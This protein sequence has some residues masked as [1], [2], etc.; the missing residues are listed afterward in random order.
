MAFF[1]GWFRGNI[2]SRMSHREMQRP[3]ESHPTTPVTCLTS[4]EMHM[5][6]SSTLLVFLGG[7]SINVGTSWVVSSAGWSYLRFTE[8]KF[9]PHI[10]IKLFWSLQDKMLESTSSGRWMR[11]WVKLLLRVW[12]EWSV[13][14]LKGLKQRFLFLNNLFSVILSFSVPLA[15]LGCWNPCPVWG[16]RC[17][18]CTS[19]P[20]WQ[21][22]GLQDTEAVSVFREQHK[23][24]LK[25]FQCLFNYVPV[26]QLERDILGISEGKQEPGIHSLLP[27]LWCEVLSE[28]WEADLP[29][30]GQAA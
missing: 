26:S 9:G 17:W 16:M 19:H 28:M 29:C 5:K 21:H 18:A 3:R 14:E 8:G 20:C 7:S 27:G 12:R 23:Y 2:Y 13:L 4:D 11:N 6:P 25:L 22:W 30:E 15:V 24:F 1:R 10:S